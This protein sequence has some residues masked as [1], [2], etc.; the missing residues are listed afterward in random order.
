VKLLDSPELAMRQPAVSL[1]AFAA[2]ARPPGAPGPARVGIAVC[3][4]GCWY[5]NAA[6]FFVRMRGAQLSVAGL[7]DAFRW[8]AAGVFGCPVQRVAV[9]QAHYV[10]GLNADAPPAGWD[11]VLADHGIIR[12]DVPVSVGKGEIGA[13]VELALTCYQ[14]ACEG[15]A[16][17]IVLVAGDGDFAP[18]AARLIGRGLPVLVPRANFSYPVGRT[19]ITVATS[20]LLTH[21]ATDTPAL[22][23][24]VDA[25]MDPGYPPFLGRPLIQAVNAGADSSAGQPARWHGTVSRWIPGARYGFITSGGLTWYASTKETPG[26]ATLAPGTKVTFTGH[27]S[28]P[29]GKLYP[30]ACA[31]IP[32]LAATATG[33]QAVPSASPDAA[34]SILPG[35]SPPMPE[36]PDAR[37]EKIWYAFIDSAAVT[38]WREKLGWS[39]GELARRSRLSVTTIN[40]IDQADRPRCHIRTVCRVAA[41]LDQPI[42]AITISDHHD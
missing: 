37:S 13:D 18:L 12:H 33:P 3:Y 41:A 28:P 21:R 17:M 10:A 1:P 35:I 25:A 5:Q 42:T 15:S 34:S 32:E 4:D 40:R 2:P 30:P 36:P 23:D 19:T 11:Q 16:D 7:H 8:H 27:A 38:R 24:L 6:R 9:T 26:H 29:P 20:A 31:I 39:R 14:I 22:T